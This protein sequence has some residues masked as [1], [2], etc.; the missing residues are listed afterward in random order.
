MRVLFCVFALC[1]A[2]SVASAETNLVGPSSGATFFNRA[3][4]TWADHAQ[5]IAA[6]Q[7]IL[8]DV[9]YNRRTTTSTGP[10]GGWGTATAITMDAVGNTLARRRTYAAGMENCMVVR[11]WRVVRLPE[12]EAAEYDALAPA[13]LQ[14]RLSELVG[15]EEPIGEIVRVFNNDMLLPDTIWTGRPRD[16]DIVSLSL[17]ASPAASEDEP[18]KPNARLPN[19]P[20]SAFPPNPRGVRGAARLPADATVI[21]IESGGSTDFSESISVRFERIGADP[22]VPAWV[23]D[24]QPAEFEFWLGG[25]DIDVIQVPPGRWRLTSMTR[26]S[27]FDYGV[28]TTDLCLGAPSFEIAAGEALFAG[29]FLANGAFGPNMDM[30]SV[31]TAIAEAPSIASR[32]RPAS[33]VNGNAYPCGGNYIYAVEVPGAPFVAGYVG[34][35]NVAA[36]APPAEEAT[37]P[38]P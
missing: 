24:G 23:E 20:R 7:Q 12:L 37:P 29:S 28:Y 18:D 4:A 31:Q 10:A 15:A 19:R 32:L 26:T 13:A 27:G 3:G 21:V 2:T 35:S 36:A 1:A 22:S 38:A 16:L 30:T 17:Q 6:C 11:G 9:S 34:G 8:A 33:Y 5:D 25:G 14:E